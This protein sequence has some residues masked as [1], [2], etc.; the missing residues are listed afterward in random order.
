MSEY[1]TTYARGNVAYLQGI[2]DI[3]GDLPDPVGPPDD[4]DSDP[5][6]LVSTAATRD[7]DFHFYLFWTWK[8]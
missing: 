1:K 7:G 5:W 4:G 3:S 2:Y 8:R 6:E